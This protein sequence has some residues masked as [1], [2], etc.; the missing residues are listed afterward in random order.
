MSRRYR[1]GILGVG[2]SPLQAPN[3]PTIGTA[4][5][6]N[7]T[8]SVAFTAPACVGG[9]PITSY[10]VQSNPGGIGAA[11][12]SSP[13]TVT[14]LTNCTAYTFRAA[15]L[16]SYGPSPLSAAS[17]SVTPNTTGQTAYTTAGTYSFVVPN[18]VTSI[19]V[20]TVGGGGAGGGVGSGGYSFSAGNGGGGG[21]LS[22]TNNL[23]VTPGE[24][25]DVVVGAGGVG[26]I[27][28]AGTAGGTSRINRS[29]TI[30][31]AAAGGSGGLP[32]DN[33]A[34]AAGGA[35]ASGTGDVKYS[36][37][38]GAARNAGTLVNGPGGGAAGYAGIGGAGSSTTTGTAGAGGGGGG[39]S[40]YAGFAGGGGGVGILGQGCNGAGGTFGGSSTPAIQGKGGSSGQNGQGT[41]RAGPGGAYGGGGSGSFQTCSA[42]AAGAVGAV[43]IIYPGATRS[44]PSTNTGDL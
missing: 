14:G 9:S 2:F 29:A 35:S 32:A 42:G 20:V 44:F 3:A 10:A 22:Y 41:G 30:L 38:A 24:T 26:A 18:A 11:G 39:G 6:G 28:T 13:I 5:R 8:A 40:G 27:N 1:G 19:S 16:N 36:G 7:T 33:T 37:G 25:L 15:A 12:T 34:T 31:V 17:N 4:V 21:A 43:R 23:S